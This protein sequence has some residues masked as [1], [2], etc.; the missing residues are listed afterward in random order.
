M[1]Y[2]TNKQQLKSISV[3]ISQRHACVMHTTR[4]VEHVFPICAGNSKYRPI[5]RKSMALLYSK[6]YEHRHDVYNMYKYLFGVP[7]P[8]GHMVKVDKFARFWLKSKQSKCK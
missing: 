3:P 4:A 2:D 5:F 8:K 1:Y 6:L 7:N